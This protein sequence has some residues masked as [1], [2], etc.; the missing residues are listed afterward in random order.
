MKRRVWEHME[1]HGVQPTAANYDQLE[2]ARRFKPKTFLTQQFERLQK[3]T[4]P[5]GHHI[6]VWMD[7]DGSFHASA[8]QHCGYVT[9]EKH[10]TPEAAI[11]HAM[12]CAAKRV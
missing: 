11:E 1:S 6:R 4:Y 10:A 12:V 5:F 3:T 9:D 8:D 2:K 7:E